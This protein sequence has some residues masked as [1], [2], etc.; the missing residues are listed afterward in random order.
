MGFPLEPPLA[1][2]LVEP[3]P[4]IAT[5]PLVS[6]PTIITFINYFNMYNT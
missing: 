4:P 6:Q 2:Y 5:V 3:Y 1:P